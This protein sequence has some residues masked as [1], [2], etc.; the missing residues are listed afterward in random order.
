[1][2]NR[3]EKFARIF[4]RRHNQT[5]FSGAGFLSALRVNPDS[6]F[7]TIRSTAIHLFFLCAL[8]ESDVTFCHYYFP[9]SA[10]GASGKLCFVILAFAGYLNIILK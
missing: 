5:T 3:F 2:Q 1:M 6:G 8:E 9:I 10:F 7:P 4:S